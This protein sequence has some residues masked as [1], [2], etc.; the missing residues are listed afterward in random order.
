MASFRPREHSEAKRFEIYSDLKAVWDGEKHEWGAKGKIAKKHK[1]SRWTVMDYW[2]LG[3]EASEPEEAWQNLK[4][5][6]K[7]NVGRKKLDKSEVISALESLPIRNRRTYRHAAEATGYSKSALMNAVR[8]GDIKRRSSG[9]KPALTDKNKKARLEFSLSFIDPTTRQFDGMY[10]RIHVDEKWF[11]LKEGKLNAI[12]GPNEEMPYRNVQSKRFITKVM[13]LCAVAR[14]R[15]D[16][17]GNVLFDGK[18]GFWPFIE[19]V[20][21][22]RSSKH[23]SKGTWELKPVN[24]DRHV[25]RDM[26]VNKLFPAIKSK[27]PSRRSPVYVQQDGAPAH[28]KDADMDVIFNGNRYGWDINLQTQPP[29]SPDF[30]VLDLGLFRSLQSTTWDKDIREIRDIVKTAEGA[31][32]SLNPHTLNDTFL[33]L[34]KHMECAMGVEGGN[35]FK[36]PHMKKVER[37]RSGEDIETF[38]CSEEAYNIATAKL[39]QFE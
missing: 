26:I 28:V 3:H 25:Y 24:V 11:Y 29:N 39:E 22:Q 34:Q 30:N 12:L 10:D 31:F 36:E 37:R 1:V 23:R 6:K 2:K 4:P 33:S 14:P 9:L 38:T 35:N 16:R 5:K 17:F 27:W 13:F 8:R 7:G 20:Q 21:A 18:I 15:F 19:E 32:K